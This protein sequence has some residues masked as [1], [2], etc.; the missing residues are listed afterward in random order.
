MNTF[1]LP[2]E[3]TNVRIASALEVLAERK[4][5]GDVYGFIIDEGNS[6]P[7][8]SVTYTDACANFIP[9]KGNNGSFDWGDWE[10]IIKNEFK[11]RP[12]VLTNPTGAVNYYLDYDDYSKKATGG[13]S[14]LTGTDGDVMTEFGTPL[15]WK[16]TRMGKRIK[17]QISANPFYGSVSHAFEIE[18]GYNQM[19]YYPLMLTQIL[20]MLMFKNRDSQTALGRGYVDSNT[21]YAT[22]GNTD[23]KGFS[24]GESTGKLQNKFLGME[25]YYGNKYY[26]ID[27]LVTDATHNLLIGKSVFNNAGSDYDKFASGASENKAGYVDSVQGGG[28]TGF[29]PKSTE[30]SASTH[31]CDYGYLSSSRVAHFGGAHSNG[32]IAGFTHL[33]LIFSGASVDASFGSR[34]FCAK[35]NKI[36]I[37]AYLGSTLE[38]KLR[39]VSNSVP[40]DT[41][42]IGAFRLE[43]QAN[44]A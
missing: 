1:N 13:A 7:E 35:S 37:G 25:D 20:Y 9:A 27:G 3:E 23:K 8:T 44:N 43:A 30:G 16:F 12:C 6:N 29:V 33:R 28:E 26:W 36:Y 42:T 24:Y 31:Y 21:E 32:S 41:K 11:I 5:E 15:H 17:V 34:L 40:S 10:D 39:S 14:N 38:G 22:T 18:D 19:P 2:S 4:Y